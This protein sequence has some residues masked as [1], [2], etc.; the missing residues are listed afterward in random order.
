MRLMMTTT[1]VAHLWFH[2]S[3]YG[4]VVVDFEDLSLPPESSAESTSADQAP[5]VSRGVE[6]NR[7][8]NND[9]DCC[10]GGW[11]YSNKTDLTTA[12][13]TNPYSAYVPGGGGAEG[14]SHFA[15]AF[16]SARGDSVVSFS[17]PTGLQ[18]MYVANTTYA[19]LA[20][21]DGNDAGAGFVKGPFENGDFFTLTVFGV[22]ADGQDTGS[23]EFHLADFVDQH[24]GVV[25]DWSWMNLQ[26]LGDVARL[27]FALS[28]SDVG[29][30]GM[31]TPAYFAIDNLTIVPEPGIK[32]VLLLTTPALAYWF[33]TRRF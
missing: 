9:F 3:A 14:S 4:A 33:R 6:F 20:V 17:E 15:V 31:N 26:E 1:F 19:F 13:F 5:F 30:F 24:T 11:A 21:K 7:T 8:W 28:S 29:Q 10:P 23:V 2:V 25:D 18:G 22:G 16:N 32:I 12:G 27:E